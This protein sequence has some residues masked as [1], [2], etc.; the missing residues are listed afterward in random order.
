MVK[1]IF[2]SIEDNTLHCLCAAEIGYDPDEGT[3]WVHGNDT[4]AKIYNL[5][6][7]QAERII[8]AFFNSD[9]L[10]L[11]THPAIIDTAFSTTESD[12][13]EGDD[14]FDLLDDDAPPCNADEPF[15][16][17]D[18]ELNDAKIIAT[19]KQAAKDY[20]NGE[21]LEVHGVLKE[22]VRAIDHYD[23]CH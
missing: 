20:E 4:L 1:V 14:D 17:Q 9:R 3:L 16:Y 7:E 18:G 8:Q 21:I 10:D 13:D 2:T 12:E 23:C 5:D 11:R 19:L 22:I 15:V 6:K